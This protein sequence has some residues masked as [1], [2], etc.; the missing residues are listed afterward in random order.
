V[1]IKAVGVLDEIMVGRTSLQTP[2]EAFTKN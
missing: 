1:K 2:R